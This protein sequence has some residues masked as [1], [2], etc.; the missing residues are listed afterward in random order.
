[1]RD[2]LVHAL[3]H[4]GYEPLPA[5]D[6]R[7]ALRLFEEREV[8]A[9]LTDVT[10]PGMGGEELARLLLERKPD[11]RVTLLTAHDLS[12]RASHLQR[13]GVAGWLRKPVDYETLARRLRELVE[14]TG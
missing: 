10:M 9:V 11:V 12:D 3:E 2:L 8:A 5:P 7:R 13:L 4:L 1:M 14:G 6:A